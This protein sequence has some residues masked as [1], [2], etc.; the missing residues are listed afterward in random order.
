MLSLVKPLNEM[1]P[2]VRAGALAVFT[3]LDDTLTADGVVTP[4]AFAA[5]WRAR[6]A[7]L[8]VVL[9]TTRPAGWC[10][11]LARL[12]PVAAVIGESGAFCFA[13]R[14]RRMERIYASREDSAAERLA[15]IER[16]VLERVPRAQVAADQA[17][18]EVDLAIDIAEEATPPLSDEEV[19][20]ILAVFAAQGAQARV[21]ALHVNGWVGDEGATTMARRCSQTFLGRPLDPQHAIYLGA[22]RASEPFFGAFPHACGVANVAACVAKLRSR[23]A[24]VTEA[25]GGAGFAE[26]IDALL[27]AR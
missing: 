5:L 10:D 24:Y 23:P 13:L 2:S 12:W 22:S 1:P 15:S 7:G 3:E 27:A 21:G 4:E 25:A 6:E 8:P 16:E 26:L 20:Q 19:E 11:H 18:R 9:V 14:G 17:Y